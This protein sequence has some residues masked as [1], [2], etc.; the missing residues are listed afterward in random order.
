MDFDYFVIIGGVRLSINPHAITPNHSNKLNE[1]FTEA[2]I[3]Q[4]M[5]SKV[6][7][8]KDEKKEDWIKRYNDQ[9]KKEEEKLKDELASDFV[10][11]AIG[12]YGF[13]DNQDYMYDCLYAIAEV[14]DQATKVTKE[15]FA[16]SSISDMNNFIARVCKKAKVP[17]EFTV[18]TGD[19]VV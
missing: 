1:K 15:G 2:R 13:K 4:H 18:D 5:Y 3:K 19:E 14:F 17:T 12:D 9:I 7:P 10:K 11:R 16:N 8:K 6:P